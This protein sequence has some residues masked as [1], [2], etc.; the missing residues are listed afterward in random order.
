MRVGI[1]VAM[2]DGGPSECYVEWVRIGRGEKEEKW[3][4]E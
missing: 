3:E 4:E 1:G 2:Q